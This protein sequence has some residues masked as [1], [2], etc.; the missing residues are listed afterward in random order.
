MKGR[1]FSL[2]TLCLGLAACSGGQPKDPNERSATELYV[3]KGVQ[4]MEAG[5][6]D[7]AQRDLQHAI[8]LDDH[9]VEAHNAMGVLQERLGQPAL[10]EE[11]FKR[12]LSLEPG[13][14]DAAI[15]YG[16]ALCAQ[17]KYEAAMKNFHTA[18]DSKLYITPWLPLTNAGICAKAQGQ[19]AE[20]ESYLRKALDAN[21]NFTP[22]LLEM[23][24]LSLEN[25]SHLSA[26]AFL[27]R[28]EAAA[29]NPTAESLALGVQIETVM[30]NTRDANTYL[31]K[32]QR[33]FPESK[34][35]LG[36]RK[37]RSAQ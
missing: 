9:N 12:A 28:Y 16:R 13:N 21:P 8:E 14:I 10:A 11:Q 27:Q 25:G 17:G 26:R 2:L 15:N 31:K 24:K 4:Y 35:A 7:V 30:G 23:A 18:I 5:R 32:L 33:L 19:A 22:A 3:L 34:E 36:Y 20:A 37:I 29:P 6:L 1:R